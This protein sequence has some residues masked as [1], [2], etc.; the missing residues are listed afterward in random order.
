[1]LKIAAYYTSSMLL[2]KVLA[3]CPAHNIRGLLAQPQSQ[4]PLDGAHGEQAQC[5]YSGIR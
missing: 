1:M 5:D 3:A 4:G 2:E